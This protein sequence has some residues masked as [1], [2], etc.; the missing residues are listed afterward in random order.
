MKRKN[1]IGMLL[2]IFLLTSCG[3]FTFVTS[4]SNQTSSNISGTNSNHSTTDNSTNSS[5][6]SISTSTTGDNEKLED[7]YKRLDIKNTIQELD[8]V[9]GALPSKGNP[10]ALVIPVEFPDCTAESKGYSIDLIEKAFNGDSLEMEWESVNSFFKKSSY[11]KVD[12]QFD[13]MDSWFTTSKQSTYY[14]TYKDPSGVI[15]PA[16]V[17]I[18]EYLTANPHNLDFSDYDT[19]GDSY[20]DSIYVIYTHEVDYNSNNTIW[21]AYQYYYMSE[22]YFNDVTPYYYVFAGYDFL[23]EDNMECNT[24]TYIHESGHLFGLEDYYDYDSK[25]G[26]ASGGLA[27]A[28]I[29]DYTVGD[30]NPFSKMLLGW[31]ANPILITTQNSVTIDLEAFQEN[32]DFV[33]LA[34]NWNE[35]D[36]MYQE[37]FIVEYWTPTGLNEYDSSGDYLY[38][39]AGIRVLHVTA[40]L[41]NT[42]GYD[43]FKYDN[44][45]SNTK[46]IT[47]VPANNGYI[48]SSTIASNAF[49]YRPSTNPTFSGARY[50]DRTKLGYEFTVNSLGDT[51]ANITFTKI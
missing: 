11:G 31:A 20:I 38:S 3:N 7:K 43:Y 10:R 44:S 34:N 29:M 14:S 13:V 45:Y 25:S 48:T 4:S 30:H 50:N 27:G 46:L 22:D 18:K 6:N 39:Q 9:S 2:G 42:N 5:T 47:L 40:N 37:Y 17:I 15:D 21:W 28:D 49:L 24:H 41:A 23:L 32:G 1:I 36:G 19:N 8:Y 51:H 35:S 26:I 33:I 16:E 12:V